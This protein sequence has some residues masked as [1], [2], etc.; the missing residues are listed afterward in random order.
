M[1]IAGSIRAVNDNWRPRWADAFELASAAAEVMGYGA[2]R[3]RDAVRENLTSRATRQN[4]SHWQEPTLEAILTLMS[5]QGNFAGTTS[6]LLATIAPHSPS[7]LGPAAAKKWP[8]SAVRL[9]IALNRIKADLEDADVAMTS[10]PSKK[11]T[12][13]T[14]QWITAAATAQGTGV[15]GAKPSETEVTDVVTFDVNELGGVAFEDVDFDAIG[16]IPEIDPA[17]LPEGVGLDI[18][19]LTAPVID[20]LPLVDTTAATN[21]SQEAPKTK[22]AEN[23][24]AID[25]NVPPATPNATA[26][27]IPEATSTAE[28]ELQEIDEVDDDACKFM[29]VGDKEVP[30][31]SAKNGKPL[32]TE[33]ECATCDDYVQKNTPSKRDVKFDDQSEEL[34]MYQS[35]FK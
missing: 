25:S 7:N 31:C 15:T 23:V 19:E 6:D 21:S 11:G 4:K 30:C 32:W 12:W 5:A 17:D 22:Y 33:S 18:A 3:Y 27:V 24:P 29:F 10:K 35:A 2:T 9:G 1:H 8:D 20:E 16:L 13:V 34:G 28:L 26:P 14:L